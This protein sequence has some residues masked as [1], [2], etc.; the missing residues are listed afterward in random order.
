MSTVAPSVES[1]DLSSRTNG[2]GIA[3]SVQD[4]GQTYDSRQINAPLLACQSCGKVRY[5][6]RARAKCLDC[7]PYVRP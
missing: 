4:T 2:A 3:T 5:T 1:I 6:T 7:E